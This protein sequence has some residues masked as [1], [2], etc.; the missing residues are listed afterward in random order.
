MSR[1]LRFGMLLII[2]LAALTFGA[3]RLVEAQT[4]TWFNKDLNLRARLAVSGARSELAS[5][6]RSSP[7]QLARVLGNLAQDE[8]I[9]GGSA[10]SPTGISV[11]RTERFPAGVRCDEILERVRREGPHPEWGHWT[12]VARLPGGDVHLSAL[13]V[14]DE[15]GELGFVVLAQDMA[16][17]E[18]RNDAANTFLLLSFGT[19]SLLASVM[20]LIA[21]RM[22]WRD[23]SEELRKILRGGSQPK[24]FQP[25]LSDV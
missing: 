9:M 16:F 14:S 21:S 24:E 25:I 12:D 1:A 17:V 15:A 23:W 4:R 8:R 5:S 18:R 2:G 6:W 7:E 10:C 22:S 11:A 20:T 19:L 13:P 3:S